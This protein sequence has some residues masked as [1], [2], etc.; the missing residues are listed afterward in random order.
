MPR[1]VLICTAACALLS[2]CAGAPTLNSSA[3]AA[4]NAPVNGVCAPA[5]ASRLKQPCPAAGQTYSQA[6]IRATGQPN[7]AQAL[8]MLDPSIH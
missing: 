2:A 4:A 7:N 5:E 8:R 6:D 3:V 1:T